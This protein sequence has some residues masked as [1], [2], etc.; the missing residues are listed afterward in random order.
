MPV[1][2]PLLADQLSFDMASL[3]HFNPQEDILLFCEVRAETDYVAHHPQKIVFLF[4]AMRHFA[5][6]C[7]DMGFRVH[8]V[9]LDDQ[10]NTHTLISEWQRVAVIHQ[11]SNIYV[12]MPGEWRLTHAIGAWQHTSSC[13]VHCFEDT[14]FLC[15][16]EE[17]KAWTK[18]K[19]QL[20]MEYFYQM[21]RKKHQ[22][23]LSEKGTP[24]GGRWNFD[25]ENREPLKG[26]ADWGTRL[27]FLPDAI[28]QD[29]II[30]VKQFF[31][32]HFGALDDFAYACT[33]QE[34]QLVFDD[35]LEHH[36]PL[37]GRYQDVMVTDETFLHHSLISIYLHVGFLDPLNVCRQVEALYR[38]GA[39]PL[40]S[41]E[42]FIR[43]ILGWREFIRGM[44]WLHMP[45]Y[46]EL[47]VLK[48]IRP[49]PALYWGAPTKMNCLKE[50]VG[51]TK[52]FAYSH[53]IQ[54]LMVT[55]NFALLAGIAP[56]EVTD[57]YLAV[58]ID[59]FEWVELPNTL[60]MSLFGDGGMVASKPYAASARYIDKMSNF[61]KKCHF[62][63]KETVGADACPFNSLYWNFIQKHTDKLR[64]N[65]RMA[66]VYATWSRFSEEKKLAILQQA[67]LYLD[68][69]DKNHL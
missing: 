34:A 68:N 15:S 59:A 55:G 56:K 9:K 12:T 4:S 44:Y 45:D 46:A 41:A 16:H 2:F 58:Y 24:E 14:R 3:V 54:R 47:N 39:V 63:S 30:L 25:T 64:N 51:M 69:L 61:C 8:Y 21:M 49:L 67:C 52:R 37:F 13:A 26:S 29:V 20:R 57:W 10:D 32:H 23:L 5:K 40:A 36:L 18:G 19:K 48:A 50:V 17:F 60:G 28:T 42:G 38:K 7:Q 31:S 6:I 11:C 66:Y 62:N 53:H 27:I 1:L 33:P 65:P 22:I 43:Q 35:F